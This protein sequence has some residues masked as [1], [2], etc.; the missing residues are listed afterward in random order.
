MRFASG[1]TRRIPQFLPSPHQSASWKLDLA[2]E[3]Q[4]V[5]TVLC[6]HVIHVLFQ[7]WASKLKTQMRKCFGSFAIANPQS[8][9]CQ[10]AYRK[11]ANFYDYFANRK[12]ATSTKYC[13]TQNSPI[14]RLFK[15]FFIIDLNQSITCY[16]CKEKKIQY[17]HVFAYLRKF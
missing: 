1:P 11:S 10:S 7:R 17:L 4:V 14:S 3:P 2:T 8:Q 13:I 9:V 5:H 15:R 16:I 6:I 12:S